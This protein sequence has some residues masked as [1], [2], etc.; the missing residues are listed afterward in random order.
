MTADVAVVVPAHDR[1]DL[2]SRTLHTVL[3][4]E[5]VDLEVVV[6][7]DGGEGSATALVEGLADPR[8]RALPTAKPHSGP[9]AARNVGITNTT[10]PWVAFLDD[11][12]VW[13]PDKL[14]SQLAAVAQMTEA[15]WVTTGAV[16]VDTEMAILA[17][18]APPEPG[19]Q[20]RQ[21]AVNLVPGGGSATVVARWVLDAV[22]GFD[23]AKRHHGDYEMW[24]RVSLAAPLATVPRP[25]TGYLK[26]GGGLSRGTAGGRASLAHM[27]P[28]MERLQEE[29]G[30]APE[31][32]QW[33]LVW[34]DLELRAGRRR[35]AAATY[36][37]RAIAQRDP[38][39]LARACLTAVSPRWALRRA[40]QWERA[41]VPESV[42]IE[43]ERW[44]ARVPSLT[45]PL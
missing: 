21:V 7:D 12:D 16:S 31:F 35:D 17:W 41:Q 2:L 5:G 1:P 8:V 4:Q 32:D 43:A 20:P 6:V 24:M 19:P 28:E 34:G 9:C 22:G 18:Q 29:L 39:L 40:Q 30:V 36:G 26:H 14:A 23:E 38:R 10:A 37:R 13:A 25:L 33:E 45:P 27:R 11:D 44:L 42:R 15:G 3:W